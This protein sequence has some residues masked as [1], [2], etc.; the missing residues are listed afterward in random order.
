MEAMKNQLPDRIGGFVSFSIPLAASIFA[1]S[2]EP[3][4]LDSPEFTAAVQTLGIPHPPGHPLYVMLAK[5]FTLLPLGGIAFRVALASAVFGALAS[6]IFFHLASRLIDT[7]A[8][9]LSPRVRSTLACTAA[10][11]VSL[12]PGWWFQCVRA[13][14]YS[15]Q[16][17]L[18]LAALYPLIAYCL[19]PGEPSDRMLYAAAFF[20]GLGLA[21]HHYVTAVALPATIPLL[22]AEAKHRGG[23]GALK[24]SGKLAAIG[25]TGLLP[26]LFLPIRSAS[27]AAVS[28][29]GVHSL[30]DFFWV[31][32]AKVYQK[33]MAKQHVQD[34]S[35]R[36]LD[37]VYTMMGELGPVVIVVSLAGL[38]FL[39]RRAP[40]RMAGLVLSLL[41]AITLFMRSVMG[42][43]PFNPDYYGYMLPALACFVLGAAVFVAIVLDTI[44]DR[45]RWGRI[46]APIVAS[47]LF[48]VP[49]ARA[50]EVLPRVDLSSFHAT[51]LLLDMSMDRAESGTLVL[52]AY[53]KLFFVLWSAR[54]I[55]GSRPDI[56]VIN[57]EFFGYP[58]YLNSTLISRPDLRDLARSMIVHGRLTEAVVADLAW[59][60]PL[61]I[62]PSLW[63]D[64]EVTRYM[65]PDGPVYKAS[66]E[67]LARSDVAAASVEHFARWRRFYHIL[68]PNSD[69]HETWRMLSWCYYQDA[70]FLARRGDRSGARQAVEMTRALGSKTPQIEGLSEALD[71]SETGPLDITPFLIPLGTETPD[72]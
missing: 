19:D 42:F 29:G 50:R 47:G 48:V 60:G 5:P 4:W 40:T 27:G 52:T 62:E 44:S 66:P 8:S 7:S 53:Y 55:D 72:S 24:L 39:L 69:E 6:F 63:L 22:V 33:S 35:D 67:P 28:L 16:I 34:L 61:R 13:E 54:F 51:R 20:A 37:A 14:V 59:R 65:L 2:P 56:T 71:N 25:V 58:G 64:D 70:L 68:G 26:Y 30:K 1:A 21:N 31:V 43:D 45:R 11:L 12:A 17:L 3:Y 32:S 23:L 15:L 18:L 38:Y 41:I 57:P 9:G 46:V 36:S 49:I 10:L